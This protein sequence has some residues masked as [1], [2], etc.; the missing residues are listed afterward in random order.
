MNTILY[1]NKTPA[2]NVTLYSP[3]K[4]LVVGT[5]LINLNSELVMMLVSYYCHTAE[6][7]YTGGAREVFGQIW[8]ALIFKDCDPE[9]I[10]TV[11]E[12]E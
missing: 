9:T 4:H 1:I 2:G 11:Y 6:C 8:E 12:K 7:I 10:L 3:N 5:K